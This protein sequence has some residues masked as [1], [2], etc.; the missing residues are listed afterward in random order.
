MKAT[1]GFSLL[2]SLAAQASQVFPV[3]RVSDRPPVYRACTFRSS[4][5]Q[6]YCQCGSWQS[7]ECWLL[8]FVDTVLLLVLL[9]PLTEE[10]QDWMCIQPT[11]APLKNA[12]CFISRTPALGSHARWNRWPSYGW[13]TL[14]RSLTYKV[15]ARWQYVWVWEAVNLM[16]QDP[17]IWLELPG[18][19]HRN[20]LTSP[21]DLQLLLARLVGQYCFARGFL[22][23]SVSCCRL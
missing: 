10:R 9:H 13:R 1:L 18:I 17:V 23:A 20:R 22:L 4:W 19:S 2:Q 12:Y 14:W 3:S 21:A 11:I 6:K 8:L 5:R 7:C 15:T 16:T